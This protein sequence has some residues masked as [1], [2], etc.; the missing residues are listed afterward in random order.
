MSKVRAIVAFWSDF[1]VG[2]RPELFLGPIVALVVAWLLVGA[3]LPGALVGGL[4]FLAIAGIGALSVG[5]RSGGPGA[6]QRNG[7]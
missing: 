3:G 2:D 5:L 6:R 7:R 4:L 1:L